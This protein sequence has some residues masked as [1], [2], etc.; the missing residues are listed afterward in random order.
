M[1]VFY[2]KLPSLWVGLRE[3]AAPLH[4]DGL[5]VQKMFTDRHGGITDG[6]TDGRTD[7]GGLGQVE[8]FKIATC[9]V[10]HYFTWVTSSDRLVVA[11]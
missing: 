9:R 1:S 6:R 7:G 5:I 4:M 11:T 2:L 3:G 10:M 8:N